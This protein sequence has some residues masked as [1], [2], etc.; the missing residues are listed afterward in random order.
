MKII[1]KS[2]LKVFYTFLLSGL[3]QYVNN[4]INQNKMLASLNVLPDST[5]LNYKL[6][7]PK[8]SY[9]TNYINEYNENEKQNKI[10]I[11]PIKLNKNEE[12]AYYLTVNIYNCTSPIFNSDKSIVRCE[13]NTY[14]KYGNEYGTLILDYI[15]N[16]ISIDPVNLVKFQI[17]EIEFKNFKDLNSINIE[18][19]NDNIE[20]N[21]CYKKTNT[22]YEISSELIEYTDLAYYKNG[23][24]DKVYYDS[25]LTNAISKYG[26]SIYNY[27][28]FKDLEFEIPD[29]IFF[30]ENQIQFVGSIWNNL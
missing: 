1:N 26:I 3:P 24:A 12:A 11:V 30:I 4:P 8:I 13:I 14:V 25:S 29:S 6:D 2:F 20:L 5:F 16:A 28:Q 23:I 9:L 15:S 21:L 10:E 19:D 27:F 18:S 17:E 22:L 7:E